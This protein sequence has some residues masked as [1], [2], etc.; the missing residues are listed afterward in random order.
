M[1]GAAVRLFVAGAF[2]SA[3]VLALAPGTSAAASPPPIP[4]SATTAFQIPVTFLSGC[5]VGFR[6]Y[7]PPVAVLMPSATTDAPGVVTFTAAPPTTA[8]DT[9]YDCLDVSVTWRNLTTGETG[10]TEIGRVPLDYSR[11]FSG[12]DSCRYLPATVSTG[13]GTVVATADVDAAA[14]ATGDHHPVGVGVGV[15]QVP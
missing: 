4:V 9:P 12:A 10:S 14:R 8:A 2:A 5:G 3:A 15:F 7:I 6:C 13:S 1:S 11:P